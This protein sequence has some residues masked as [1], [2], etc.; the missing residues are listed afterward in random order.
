[1]QLIGVNNYNNKKKKVGGGGSLK[2]GSIQ[3]ALELL[4]ILI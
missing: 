4:E 2:E 3:P 1:V